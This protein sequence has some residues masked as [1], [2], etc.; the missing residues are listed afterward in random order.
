MG[1]SDDPA[2]A[3]GTIYV[4]NTEQ[5][6]WNWKGRSIA[7]VRA[8]HFCGGARRTETAAAAK[9]LKCITREKRSRGRLASGLWTLQLVEQSAEVG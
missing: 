1:Q 5:W 2:K 7:A 6:K 9:S 8:H 4:R 3:N